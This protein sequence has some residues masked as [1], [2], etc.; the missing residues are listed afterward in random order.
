MK[1]VRSLPLA[2]VTITFCLTCSTVFAQS[3]RPS[4]GSPQKTPAPTPTPAPLTPEQQK[5]RALLRQ[6]AFDFIEQN[7]YLDAFPIL[8]KIAPL[9]PNDADVWAHY[10]IAIMARSATL[11]SPK[12]RRAERVKGHKALTKAKQ[13]GTESV[14]ALS[15]LDKVPADGGEDDNLSS[16]NPEYEKNMR[17]GEAFFGRG[18]YEKAFASYEKA[19]KI[20]PKSYEAALFMG[21]SH[22]AAKRY[23]ESEPW[24]AKAVEIDQNR[25]QAYRFW[26]DALMNQGKTLEAR[27]KFVEALIAEPYD[28]NTWERLISWMSEAQTGV[29]T[30]EITP[31]GNEAAGEITID[32]RLLKTEDGTVHWRLYN[33]ARDSRKR[34]TLEQETAA[35]RKIAEAMKKDLLIGRTKNPHESVKNLVRLSEANLIEPYILILRI[36]DSL[37]EEYQPYRAKNRDKLKRFIIEFL[38]GM[39]S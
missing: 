2:I 31:P 20:N 28:R 38:I 18:E 30:L 1:N 4:S 39:K 9:Y 6:M 36:N 21:D 24:F 34:R 3:A 29:S 22:Y 37:A 15:I 35:L 17:E 32:E 33:E 8:E 16:D 25:E 10:G 12:E 5:E 23:K 19:F 11:S 14:M 7:R 27:D 26:G 13:L